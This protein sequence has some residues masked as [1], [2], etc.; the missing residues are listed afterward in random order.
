MRFRPVFVDVLPEFDLIKDGEIWITPKLRT[1]NLRCPCG[2]GGLTV[3]SLHPSRWHLFF[4]GKSVS[5]EGHGEGSVW[6]NSGCGSHYLIRKNDVIWLDRIEPRRH[7]EYAKNELR[8]MITSTPSRQTLGS[9]I[10]QV[11][12]ILSMRIRRK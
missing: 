3:L 2:C 10:R 12:R 11:W 8:R 1:V 7:A 5:I 4:D 6:S 9:R